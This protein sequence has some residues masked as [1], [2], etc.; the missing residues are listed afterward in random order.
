MCGRFTLTASPDALTGFFSLADVPPLEPRY[1]IAPTQQVF[2]VRADQ[3]GHR[4]VAMLRWGL[5]PSWANDPGIGNKMLNARSETAADKPSFGAAIRKR[6]CLI[7]ASGFFEWQKTSAKKQPY[8]IHSRDDGPLAFAGLWERWDR[9][10]RPVESCTIL[11]T[12]ANDMMRPLHDRMP[13]ILDANDF[14]RWLDPTTQDA[15]ELTPLMVPCPDDVLT[16]YPVSTWV[17]NVRNQ[18]P[19][20]IEP[21]GAG[22][23][24]ELG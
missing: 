6:R 19:K 12:C 10:E 13:V 23:P 3:N 9:G 7:A 24:A 1:N 4:Q 20:C 16:A 15:Q 21:V 22:R 8:Y 2:A 18:G 17:N 5:I 11:T 14:N